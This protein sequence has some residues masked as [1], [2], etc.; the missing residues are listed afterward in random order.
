MVNKIAVLIS[1]KGTGSNLAA[2]LQ[3]IDD[4]I[5]RNGKVTV[6]V[7]D[8]KEAKG[9]IHACKRN[10]P[11]E[12]KGLKE[13]LQQGKTRQNYDYDL[14]VM[15]KMKYHVDLVV[16]AGWMLILGK[17]FLKYFPD[18]VINLHPGLLPD[19]DID[20]LILSDGIKVKAIRGLHT[21]AAVQFAIDHHYPVTGS[22]VHFVTPLVDQGPVIIRSEVKIKNKDNVKTLYQR[23]KK[24]EHKI[25]PEAI[26]L[27]CDNRLKIEDGR[28]IIKDAETSSA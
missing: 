17:N 2:I 13:Y 15:L 9:L 1:D 22:T 6:V 7:S 27:F 18:K 3:A 5:I 4:G 25:L 16:L 8:K 23:M 21:D 12:I 28:V 14:G 26:A 10:I 24:A 19:G 20:Y 11:A